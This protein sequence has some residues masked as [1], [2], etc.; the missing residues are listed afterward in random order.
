MGNTVWAHMTSDLTSASEVYKLTYTYYYMT[1]D[2]F[3]VWGQRV[4]GQGRSFVI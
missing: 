1:D 2:G 4:K 3:N